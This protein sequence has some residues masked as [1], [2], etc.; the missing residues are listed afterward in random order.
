MHWAETPIHVIDFEGTPTSGVVEYGIAS[1]HYSEIVATHTDLCEPTGE[2]SLAES[3]QHGL[4]LSDLIATKPFEESLPL[5]TSIRK[6]GPLCAHNAAYEDKLI[7]QTWPYTS[8]CTNYIDPSQTSNNWGPW[9]DTCQ[10]YRYLFPSQPNHKLINLIHR[11]N[12]EENLAELSKKHCPKNRRKHHCAL[13]DALASALLLLHLGTLKELRQ[14]PLQWFIL[15]SCSSIK[16]K[17]ELNQTQLSL[18]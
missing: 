14:A 11:F 8:D 6:T 18:F 12:L 13:Y 3:H 1:I 16:K 7:T 9:I 17:N 2:L 4:F 15:N 5:F 10:L